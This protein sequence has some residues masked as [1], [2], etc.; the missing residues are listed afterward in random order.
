MDNH[1][2]AQVTSQLSPNFLQSA[3]LLA[4]HYEIIFLFS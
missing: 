2:Q 3:L 4:V 1:P